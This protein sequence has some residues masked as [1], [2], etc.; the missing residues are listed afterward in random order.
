MK[1]LFMELQMRET[2][3]EIF[4]RKVL[5]KLKAKSQELTAKS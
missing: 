3:L 1:A 5:E 2:L 4:S